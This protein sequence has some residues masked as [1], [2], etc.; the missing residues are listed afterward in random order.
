MQSFRNTA[1]HDV[2]D[3][4]QYRTV[5]SRSYHC[6]SCYFLLLPA[7]NA[8]KSNIINYKTITSYPFEIVHFTWNCVYKVNS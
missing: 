7:V 8:S 6:Y 4:S 2:Y 5:T 1:C 3:K